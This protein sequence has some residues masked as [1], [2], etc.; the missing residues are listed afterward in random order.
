M[1]A[2]LNILSTCRASA[3]GEGIFIV[4]NITVN[5]YGYLNYLAAGFGWRLGSSSQVQNYGTWDITVSGSVIMFYWET[6]GSFINYGTLNIGANTAFIPYITFYNYGL[7][8]VTGSIFFEKG[9]TNKVRV[10]SGTINM[11]T[12][13]SFIQFNGG[14]YNV[15]QDALFQDSFKVIVSGSSS[16]TVYTSTWPRY[17][18]SNGGS[19]TFYYTYISG[20]APLTLKG[21][22]YFAKSAVIQNLVL[23]NAQM[24]T[25]GKMS[26]IKRY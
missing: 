14:S 24:G 23:N 7:L 16:V 11:V 25:S 4:E 2:T 10:I 5:N 17:W 20:S 15:T 1:T 21:S 18:V 9:S 12:S 26:T 19:V 6:D 22:T 3:G 8:N 13:N